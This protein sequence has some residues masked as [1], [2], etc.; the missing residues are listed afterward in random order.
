MNEPPSHEDV[1]ARGFTPRPPSMI[2]R[3]FASPA[4]TFGTKYGVPGPNSS[5]GYNGHNGNGN[6]GQAV[7]N[8]N[9]SHNGPNN[10]YGHAVN[11]VLPTSGNLLFSP[12]TYGESP[13][14]PASPVSAY[15]EYGHPVANNPYLTR[16]PSADAN[17]NRQLSTAAASDRSR[18]PIAQYANYPQS[19]TNNGAP[20]TGDSDYVDL[21]RSSV[22]PFQAAQYAEISR[23][24]NSQVPSG[25]DTP[26]AM[27]EFEKGQAKMD[28]L[29]EYDEDNAPPPIPEKDHL[30]A[31]P[32][33]GTSP[34]SDPTDG[35]D[36]GQ[37]I[38]IPPVHTKNF[39]F[40]APPSPVHAAASRY[41][42]DSTPP[43]L[44]EIKLGIRDSGSNF[45]TSVSGFPVT[46]SPLGSGFPMTP[47]PL[48]S[49]FPASGSGPSLAPGAEKRRPET[50]YDPE[51]AYGGM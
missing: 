48:A 9:R 21:S 51:D 13:F 39:E 25:L 35:D 14:S 38:E 34:F 15:D 31:H 20:P 6:Y 17:I 24:L 19:T 1:V 18:P 40:P 12:G 47:S 26:A 11:E 37:E 7:N 29:P 30:K 5:D 23:E 10:D 4:P 3:R 22:T 33:P 32:A 41:R 42:I 45:S 46:P 2:E 28:T 16:Q 49:S 43:M 8:Y 27:V 36:D 50:V 44:P